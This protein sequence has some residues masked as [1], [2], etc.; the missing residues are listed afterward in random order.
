[1]TTVQLAQQS[2]SVSLH[3][4]QRKCSCGAATTSSRR[5]P[6]RGAPLCPPQGRACRGADRRLGASSS[7]IQVGKRNAPDHEAG[8]WLAAAAVAAASCSLPSFRSNLCSCLLHHACCP[9]VM[10]C[11]VPHL[12]CRAQRGPHYQQHQQL[13]KGRTPLPA[14]AASKR[15]R[16]GSSRFV[17]LQLQTS[18][19]PA[20]CSRGPLP[21]ACR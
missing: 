9:H 16:W 17:L 4:E 6:W 11:Q 3:A 19:L 18:D 14:F 8:S 15:R 7:S 13:R 10:S 5:S 12:L 1:M 21:A 2:T 20:C